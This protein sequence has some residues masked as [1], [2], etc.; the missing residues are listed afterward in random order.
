MLEGNSTEYGQV[1]YETPGPII[2][3]QNNKK[4]FWAVLNLLNSSNMLLTFWIAISG[5]APKWAAD[6]PLEWLHR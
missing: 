5:F 6:H 1:V 2:I 4:P 3:L